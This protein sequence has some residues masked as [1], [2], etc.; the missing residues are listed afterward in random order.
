MLNV[1]VGCM[2]LVALTNR[3][4]VDYIVDRTLLFFG[5]CVLFKLI[6]SSQVFGVVF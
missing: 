1:F 2:F 3:S 4:L 5:R 6:R